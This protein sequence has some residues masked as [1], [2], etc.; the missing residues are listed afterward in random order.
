MHGAKD[1][2]RIMKNSIELKTNGIRLS[3]SLQM[4]MGMVIGIA[5]VV[6]CALETGA[7][8]DCVDI[9]TTIRPRIIC[10]GEE[11]TVSWNVRNPRDIRCDAFFDLE[12]GEGCF[13]SVEE[14][15]EVVMTSSPEAVFPE[16]RV[17]SRMGVSGSET[18]VG[19]H[20]TEIT[21]TVFR[22]A[23][24][25]RR[26]FCELGGR[27]LQVITEFQEATETLNFGFGC[28]AALGGG[29]GWGAT[30]IER[31]E[32][33]SSLIQI[34]EVRNMSPFAVTVSVTRDSDDPTIP[35]FVQ[36]QLEAFGSAA[37]STT[38]IG[39]EYFGLW[40]ARP[41]TPAVFGPD[42]CDS[43]DG[44]PGDVTAPSGGDSPIIVT[45]PDVVLKVTLGCGE[46]PPSK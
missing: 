38:E 34:R 12:F 11:V 23:T 32:I 21:F 17:A 28:N 8:T 36:V 22:R 39:S 6:G 31:G 40:T 45:R 35:H 18:I 27:T 1:E 26:V 37:D 4:R 3:A 16:G 30:H 2:S 14:D 9:E 10:P 41:V 15:V 43:E 7:S 42:G 20:D 13:G 5:A 29:S 25:G 33:A 19:F 24:D 46:T 44:T